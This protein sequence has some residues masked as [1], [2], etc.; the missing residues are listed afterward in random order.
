ML[1]IVSLGLSQG[2][3]K[4]NIDLTLVGDPINSHLIGTVR[5]HIYRGD[6]SESPVWP[7]APQDMVIDKVKKY[8][9]II[10]RF[11]T[12]KKLYRL[13]GNNI[14]GFQYSPHSVGFEPE[15]NY[16][17]QLINFPG[18][19]PGAQYPYDNIIHF[20]N[21]AILMNADMMM[22]I[23]IGTLGALKRDANN[24][25]MVNGDGNP[26]FEFTPATLDKGATM[27]ANFVKYLC[28][29]DVT[30]DG[31]TKKAIDL[32]AFFEMGNENAGDWIRGRTERTRNP[33]DYLATVKKFITKMD[34]EAALHGKDLK[35]ALMGAYNVA[36]DWPDGID[37]S[38]G[39]TIDNSN[40]KV[41][42]MKYINSGIPFDY[43]TF[44]GYQTAYQ[45]A[46]WQGFCGGT[47]IDADRM[48]ELALASNEWAETHPK[49]NPVT[50]DNFGGLKDIQDLLAA[51][52]K[53]LVNTEY[54]TMVHKD[55]YPEVVQ[56]IT[57]A[58][59]CADNIIT[60]TKLGIQSATNLALLHIG[61]SGLGNEWTDSQFW[62][63]GTMNETPI[64]KTQRLIARNFGQNFIKTNGVNIPTTSITQC[65]NT[66]NFTQHKLRFVSTKDPNGTVYTLVINN[67]DTDIDV[68]FNL[69]ESPNGFC[70][71]SRQTIKGTSYTSKFGDIIEDKEYFDGVINGSVTEVHGVTI[72]AFSINIMT[73][74]CSE[75]DVTID[76]PEDHIETIWDATSVPF[77][78]FRTITVKSGSILTIMDDVTLNFC[79]SGQLIIEEGARVNLLGGKL[80]SCGQ[81]QGVEMKGRP[82][83]SQSIISNAAP[84]ATSTDYPY[85]NLTLSAQSMFYSQ[86]GTNG[87]AIIENAVTGINCSQPATN[88][89]P[90]SGGIIIANNTSFLNNTT[91][92]RIAAHPSDSYKANFYSCTFKNNIFHRHIDL[93]LNRGTTYSNCTFESTLA[94]GD[95][96]N[97]GEGYGIYAFGSGFDVSNSNFKGLFSGTYSSGVYRK[98]PFTVVG[99]H[100]ERCGFGIS[101]SGISACSI[102]GNYFTLG[103]MPTQYFGHILDM[104]NLQ[105]GVHYQYLMTGL[106]ISENWFLRSETL[107]DVEPEGIYVNSIGTFNNNI[108]SNYFSDLFIGNE[109]VGKNAIMIS[110]MDGKSPKN[111]GL[112]YKCNQNMGYNTGLDFLT[113]LV[114]EPY[115]SM[116]YLHRINVPSIPGAPKYASVG[117]SFTSQNAPPGVTP[118]PQHDFNCGNQGYTKYWVANDGP[119][120]YGGLH[121]VNTIIKGCGNLGGIQNPGPQYN[122]FKNGYDN[123][124]SNYDNAVLLEDESLMEQ[125]ASEVAYYQYLMDQAASEG[126]K[127]AI[128][129]IDN[130]DIAEVR[131]WMQKMN[132]MSGDMLLAQ[133]YMST[134]ENTLALN[135]L[136]N[137]P[138]KFNLEGNSLADFQNVKSI[139]VA[140]MNHPIDALPSN[141]IADM[142]VWADSKDGQACFLSRDIFNY[143][144][145]AYPPVVLPHNTPTP[146]NRKKQDSFEK[147]LSK[148][149]QFIISPNPVKDYVTFSIHNKNWEGKTDIMIYDITGKEIKRL[150]LPENTTSFK[151]QI[152]IPSGI[153]ICKIFA[154]NME[155]LATKMVITD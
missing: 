4:I 114:E 8:G 24:T 75:N 144:G 58:L 87:D 62:Q 30:V 109:A 100:F 20:I 82:G 106:S 94:D 81:W 137:I 60:A 127:Q 150:A 59:Y 102:A 110:P 12:H 97:I 103:E 42:I 1:L 37:P 79:E 46:D 140:L 111:S 141:V 149:V 148:T 68:D 40:R 55:K 126:Y 25:V 54:G 105:I 39:E 70:S 138:N 121:F 152:N 132:S 91:G 95:D 63:H 119:T 155:Q 83:G 115:G 85:G 92:V 104:E 71:I 41:N 48:I 31:E 53:Q 26:I 7:N 99:S 38:T 125:A 120:L 117:N 142:T 33:D 51:N 18:E 107:T 143:L 118:D 101:D 154:D 35:Y 78:D 52:G 43:V 50:S 96:F 80:T 93:T 10:P 146:Q 145:V 84:D 77:C 32:V 29:L 122:Q 72:P 57:E 113:E 2:T 6:I 45:F 15:F 65:T 9:E 21:E 67:S 49:D 23:N 14:D 116:N 64:L 151:Y 135:I 108:V 112:L 13:G 19:E 128:N 124:I 28:N 139:L 88:W 22:G 16:D 133:D 153:Y 56:S 76:N 86:A 89:W 69:N 11:G 34:A 98:P 123:A 147:H 47:S 129:N 136:D 44:H 36:F 17:D 74:G 5:N 66:G 27:A 73:F 61:T 131:L 3:P 90:Y 134:G 130:L